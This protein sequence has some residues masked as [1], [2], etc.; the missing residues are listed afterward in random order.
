MYDRRFTDL[1]EYLYPGDVLVLN[2]TRVIPARLL[3]VKES[4]GKVEIL[5]LRKTGLEWEA[6]TKP[7]RRL[8]PGYRI[9]FP[10]FEGVEAV[11]TAELAYREDG[12]YC[13]TAMSFISQAGHIPLPPYIERSDE[14]VDAERYQTVYAKHSGSAARHS[15]THH[16]AFGEIKARGL[17]SPLWYCM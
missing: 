4:G 5:L 2:D 15:C 16:P 13:A 14:A 17:K 8:R 1:V 12:F 6:L 7:S 10:G 11:I 9:F 3:G